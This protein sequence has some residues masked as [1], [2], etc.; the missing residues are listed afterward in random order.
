MYLREQN[1]TIYMHVGTLEY[2]M[3]KDMRMTVCS[4][5]GSS[6]CIPRLWAW[7]ILGQLTEQWTRSQIR[8]LSVTTSYYKEA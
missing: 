7:L 6:S 3:K 1:G 2:D 4:Y 8:G 5:V